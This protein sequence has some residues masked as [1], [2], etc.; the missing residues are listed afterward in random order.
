MNTDV[1]PTE[2]I[3][4]RVTPA[5]SRKLHAWAR[6][7]YQPLPAFLRRLIARAIHEEEERLGCSLLETTLVADEE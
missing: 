4:I 6:R 2:P 3:K 5:V 7:E 1:I